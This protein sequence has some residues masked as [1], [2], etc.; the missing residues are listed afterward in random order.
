MYFSFWVHQYYFRRLYEYRIY[1]TKC[2]S[3][4]SFGSVKLI[5]QKGM[6]FDHDFDI[7]SPFL[8]PSFFMREEKRITKVA[9]KS[10][11]ILLDR[12]I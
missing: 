10:H 1:K 11:A 5:E 7:H 3:N 4:Q 9:V 8:L 2:I 12:Q 6:T